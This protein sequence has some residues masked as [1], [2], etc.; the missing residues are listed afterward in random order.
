MIEYIICVYT[1]IYTRPL[2]VQTE[3][4]RSYSVVCKLRL[5]WQP[6]HLNGRTRDRHKVQVSYVFCVW[7]S[8]VQCREHMNLHDF[9]W[10]LLAASIILLYNN[11]NA[12]CWKLYVI[13]KL[14]CALKNCSRCGEPYFAGDAISLD[15][16]LV[17]VSSAW[18]CLVNRITGQSRDPGFS[19]AV[20]TFWCCSCCEVLLRH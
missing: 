19:D 10:I 9:V 3:N 1:I 2:S 4:S 20:F 5:Q 17:L 12:V 13:R 6:T 18:L 15:G 7:L 8:L 16:Y 11:K 14:V